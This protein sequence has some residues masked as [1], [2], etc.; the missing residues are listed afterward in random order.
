MSATDF[1]HLILYA[2]VEK[3]SLNDEH[4]N[5]QSFIRYI[6]LSKSIRNQLIKFNSTSISLCSQR[7]ELQGKRKINELYD[8]ST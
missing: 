7:D 4:L 3:K 1:V 2:V 6:I 8:K 5:M